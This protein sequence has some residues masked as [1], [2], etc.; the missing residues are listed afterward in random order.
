MRRSDWGI[1]TK[2]GELQKRI[3]LDTNI[4]GFIAKDIERIKIV[5]SIIGNTNTIVYGNKIIRNELRDIPGKLKSEGKN[6]RIDILNLYDSIVKN[7]NLE[8]IDELNEIADSYY[9][10][11]REFGGSKSKESII[12]DF[13]IV[14]CASFYNMDIV[15]SSDEKSMT[16]E[17]ALRAYKL[18][19]SILKKRTP[20]F[21]DYIKLRNYLRGGKSNELV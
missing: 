13:N 5:D 1:K 6:V 20:E 18:V 2:M 7:H 3:L 19:N 10:A 14:A 12:T 11:Y 8:L 15:V 17:N 9:R 4:Y 16:T 21:I